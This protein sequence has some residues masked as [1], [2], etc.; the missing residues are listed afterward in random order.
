MKNNL[1]QNTQ[2]FS[3]KKIDWNIIQSEMK[4]KSK[5]VLSSVGTLSKMKGSNY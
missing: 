1:N 4:E 5:R 3:E 2:S